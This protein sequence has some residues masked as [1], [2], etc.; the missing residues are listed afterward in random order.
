MHAIKAA[1]AGTSVAPG[2]FMLTGYVERLAELPIGVKN[3]K[4]NTALGA[5]DRIR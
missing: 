3:G 4:G 5:T 1:S 2:S